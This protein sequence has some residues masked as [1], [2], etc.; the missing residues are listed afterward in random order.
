MKSNVLIIV[1]PFSFGPAAIAMIIEAGLRDIAHVTFSAD[2]DAAAFIE[3]HQQTV[4]PCVRGRFSSVFTDAQSLEAF[5]LIISVNHD[6]AIRHLGRL[7]LAGRGVFVDSVLT[8]RVSSVPMDMPPG[9]LA[10]LVQDYP[11]AGALLTRCHARTVALTSPFI[12]PLACDVTP[13]P[14]AGILLHLGGMTSPYATW[15]SLAPAVSHIARQVGALAKRCGQEMTIVGS[16]RLRELPLAADDVHVLGDVSPAESARQIASARLVVSTPGIGAVYEA[17]AHDTPIVVL[18]AMNSTQLHNYRM[19]AQ[20]GIPG[21]VHPDLMGRVNAVA[22]KVGWD[23]QTRLSL[24]VL[25]DFPVPVLSQLTSIC[26]PLLAPD[27]DQQVRLRHIDGQR[28][29]LGV[30]SKT[31]PLQLLRTLAGA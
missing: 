6:P 25:Q 27:V 22:A 31:D 19:L 14:R 1:A 9:L 23:Q 15:E 29:L 13:S 16:A 12:W 3:R 20:H 28:A 10:Y 11:G 4:T 2:G 7:G 5:D 21:T 26:L 18:P 8:W 24:K 17:I 30:L